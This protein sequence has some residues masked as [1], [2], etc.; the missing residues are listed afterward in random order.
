MIHNKKLLSVL[1]A[2]AAVFFIALPVSAHVTVNPSQ[3][4]TE[5][6]ETYQVRIP[7]EKNVDTTKVTIK[8]PENVEF[9]MYAPVDGWKTTTTTDDNGKVATVTWEA[10]SED[11]AIKAGQYRDFTFRAQ[12]P[13]EPGDIA[14][15]AF[16]YYADGSIVEWTGDSDS[17][18]PHSITSIA[19]SN[20]TVDSHGHSHGTDEA[21]DDTAD[22]H[23][24]S[25]ED[26]EHAHEGTNVNMI[27]SIIAIV[28]SV[29]AIGLTFI[30]KK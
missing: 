4:T 5:A 1:V 15:D 11:T 26:T 9:K 28:L 27:L 25:D 6:W 3:S 14:W 30:R 18:L 19:Q 8:I 20:E 10:E 16:Q 21:T 7:V 29:V 23:H 12:N 24:A 2:F 13:K 22:D 17:E